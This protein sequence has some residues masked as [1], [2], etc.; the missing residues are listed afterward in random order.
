MNLLLAQRVHKINRYRAYSVGLLTFLESKSN[1]NVGGFWSH[2]TICSWMTIR[3]SDANKKD[4][5]HS[6][7][8]K[9][10]TGW[11]PKW[12]SRGGQYFLK[13]IYD[14]WAWSGKGRGYFESLWVSLCDI[15]SSLSIYGHV[16]LWLTANT[17]IDAPCDY[18]YF[19]FLL[20]V[21]TSYKAYFD[22]CK[23]SGIKQVNGK[24]NLGPIT[25]NYHADIRNDEIWRFL[26]IHK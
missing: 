20:Q 5:W 15:V 13:Y 19:S 18:T 3:K 25:D 22:Q 8:S 6:L 16:T 4:Q 14:T 2:R 21:R 1:Q 26:G 9:N 24:R 10:S 11:Y 12:W 7:M 17:F 23:E